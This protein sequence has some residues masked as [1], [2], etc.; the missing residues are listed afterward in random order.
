MESCARRP[1]AG[2]AGSDCVPIFVTTGASRTEGRFVTADAVILGCVPRM[3]AGYAVCRSM[4]NGLK[5]GRQSPFALFDHPLESTVGIELNRL[6]AATDLSAPARRRSVLPASRVTGAQL[7]LVHATTAPEGCA[8]PGRFRQTWSG[9]SMYCP[10]QCLQ[11]WRFDGRATTLK[12]HDGAL[13]PGPTQCHQ[14]TWWCWARGRDAAHA[15]G[16]TARTH[17]EARDYARCLVKQ[18]PLCKPVL[19]PVD[20][21]PF[22]AFHPDCTGGGGAPPGA[23]AC[24]TCHARHD[25]NTPVGPTA[26]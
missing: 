4:Q 19:V 17:G 26:H 11:S 9:S 22:A 23:A 6:V 21:Q 14:P 12:V 8:D 20:F 1:A 24:L 2:G 3:N 10:A 15:A 13:L 18:A 25:R 7:D 5:H 16:S